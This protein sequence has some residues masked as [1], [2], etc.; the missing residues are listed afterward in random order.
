MQTAP[1]EV[2]SG[3]ASKRH[4]TVCCMMQSRTCPGARR[5]RFVSWSPTFSLTRQ[6]SRHATRVSCSRR[7]RVDTSTSISTAR[8]LS[9]RPN[10]RRSGSFTPGKHH[11]PLTRRT[12][13]DRR[14]RGA[15]GSVGVWGG[16]AT[17]LTRTIREDHLPH[18]STRSCHETRSR[19]Q[20]GRPETQ[21]IKCSS[22]HRLS[23]RR[24]TLHQ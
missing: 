5:I 12:R 18:L 10:A 24:R 6:T 22:D 16:R 8:S 21:V 9:V 11:E 20:A 19:E 3:R 14:S 1:W 7:A 13:D 23:G 4:S 15:R 17:A 2:L